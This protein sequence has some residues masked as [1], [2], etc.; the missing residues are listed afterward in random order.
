MKEVDALRERA[1]ELRCL[2]RVHEILSRRGQPPAHAFLAVLE[3][4]PEGW[5]RPDSTGARIEYLG[6]SYVGPG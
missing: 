4:I 6:R 3:A 2:Y 1:K 5:Q